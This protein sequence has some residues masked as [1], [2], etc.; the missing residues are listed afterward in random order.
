MNE[1]RYSTQD[2]ADE[3][4]VSRKTIRKRAAALGIG[5]DLEGRAGFRY[6]DSD[7][8]KFIES[9]RPVVTPPQRKRKRAA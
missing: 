3:F 1:Y 2:L 8:A 7:R 9:M 6:S 5:I 4:G